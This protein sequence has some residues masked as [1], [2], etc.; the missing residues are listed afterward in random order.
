[1]K[2]RQVTINNKKKSLD[3]RTSKGV[4][5]LPYV[6]LRIRPTLT[7]PVASAFVDRELANR[8]VT[9]RLR[10]GRED[11]VHL[12]AFLDYNRDPAFMRDLTL[13]KMTIQALKLFRQSGLSKHE[14]IRRL[15]TSPSH[16]YRL[17]NPACYGKSVDEMLRLLWVLG[18]GVD[19]KIF[20]QA[21]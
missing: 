3:V 9:Y 10:S 20:K 6:K 1:M 21:A 8:G 18:Y 7:D 5:S 19:V 11:S 13:H 14:V 15:S 2:I 17:L 16:L 4:Y 12:D